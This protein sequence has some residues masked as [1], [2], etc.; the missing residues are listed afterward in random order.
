MSLDIGE[1]IEKGLDRAL[2]RNSAILMGMFFLVSIISQVFGDTIMKNLIEK[3]NFGPQ[4]SEM[5]SQFSV[6]ELAPLALGLSTEAAMAGSMLVSLISVLV[7][8]GTVRTFLSEGEVDIKASYFTDNILW[9]LANTIAG[10]FVFGLAVVAGF[11]AF[12]IPGVFLLVSLFFWSFYVIDQDQNFFEAL[13]S[14]WIDTKGNRLMTFAL[15]II[16]FIGNTVFNAVVGTVLNVAGAF[17][18]GL[19]IGSVLGLI[20]SAVA[21]VFTWAIFTEAYRQISE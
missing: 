18:G 16:V 11:G 15:L 6:S 20:P 4:F 8:V 5:I 13:K 19:A 7:T 1:A 12:I 2:N 3:G 9:I 10:A 21:I 17:I 14:A